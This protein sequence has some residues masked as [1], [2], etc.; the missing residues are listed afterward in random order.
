MKRKIEVVA[1]FIKK[2]RKFLIV[3]KEDRWEFPGGKV[4][5][6]EKLKEALRREIREELE[7][8]IEVGKLLFK[9]ERENYIFYFFKSRI[10]E[11]IVSLKEHKGQEWI[12]L[13]EINKF[14][15][16]EPDEKFLSAMASFKQM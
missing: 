6:G 4:K 3:K 11:G 14:K 1:S 2:G 7:V 13:K 16:Y 15:F 5:E 12:E 10:R 8:E 9:Y